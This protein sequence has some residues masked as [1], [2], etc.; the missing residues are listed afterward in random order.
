ME[1][2]SEQDRVHTAKEC[3]ETMNAEQAVRAG[4]HC[5]RASVALQFWAPPIVINHPRKSVTSKGIF[6][7]VA[8]VAVVSKAQ[9]K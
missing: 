8:V 2:R 7:K 6:V 5:A 4:R 3:A 9:R 1:N